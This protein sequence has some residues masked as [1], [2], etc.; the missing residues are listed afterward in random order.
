MR[1]LVVDNHPVVVT[2]CKL[3]FADDR[4]VEIIEATTAAE[5]EVV[6]AASKPDVAV[7]DLN[8]PDRSGL[9][10][11]QRLL[12]RDRAAKILIF[13]MCD[14]P[15]FAAKS[16]DVGARG[17]LT[18]NSDPMELRSAVFKIAQG[19]VSL[20]PDVAQG[21]ALLRAGVGREPQQVLTQRDL[22]ILRSIASGQTLAEIAGG[23][24]VSYK[25]VAQTCVRMREKLNVRNQLDLL[26]KAMRE[27][28]I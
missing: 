23:M 13:T 12:D 16:L 15:M 4:D 3:V 21:L 14:D 26:H 28:Y 17:Y 7:V 9:E 27:G 1:L 2:G 5:A 22:E 20:T 24:K 11:T 6:Y 19:G 10:L 18:K 8:L 25:T